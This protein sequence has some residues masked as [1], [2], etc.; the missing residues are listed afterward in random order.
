MNRERIAAALAALDARID[1]LEKRVRDLDAARLA[2]LENR[3]ATLTDTAG[4]TTR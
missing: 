2:R 4:D 1:D 3:A